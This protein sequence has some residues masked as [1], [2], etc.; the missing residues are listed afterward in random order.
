MLGLLFSLSSAGVGCASSAYVLETDHFTASFP[1]GWTVSPGTNGRTQEHVFRR[2]GKLEEVR[3]F[4]WLQRATVTDPEGE[5][6]RRLQA[7]NTFEGASNGAH[8]CGVPETTVTFLGQATIG[9]DLT[10]DGRART[11]IFAGQSDGSLIA[12]VVRL[13]ASPQGTCES[14]SPAVASLVSSI[15]G[16]PR[17]RVAPTE[18]PVPERP[19]SPTAYH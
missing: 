19:P 4:S 1:R 10:G 16:T 8:S 12:V 18:L 7:N 13:P 11:M 2:D 17:L 5:A 14:I 15:N 6:L 9:R 3:V